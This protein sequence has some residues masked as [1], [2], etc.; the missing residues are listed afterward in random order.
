[1]ATGVYQPIVPWSP[2]IYARG[3][4]PLLE[5]ASQTFKKGAPLVSNA[6]YFE[7]AGSSPSTIAY[8][9]AENAHNA[10]SDGLKEILAWRIVAGDVF[11]ISCEDAHAVTDYLANWGLVKDATTGFWYAD[12]GNTADQVTF[13]KPV[14]T[15][16]LGV[17][18]DTKYRALFEFQTANI[19]GA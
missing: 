11:E 16:Q 13:L 1:M 19:A 6:G 17:V 5:K 7:E 9:A 18:G 3:T 8:I 2:E 12:S 4:T 14:K 15:P 10:A